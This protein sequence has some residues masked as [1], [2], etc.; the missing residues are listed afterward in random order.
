MEA[1]YAESNADFVRK[2]EIAPKEA[3]ETEI[4]LG[5]LYNI[6]A[7][8]EFTFKSLR[9]KCGKIRRMLIASVTTVKSKSNGKKKFCSKPKSSIYC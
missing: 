6:G 2:L 7:I 5:V 4:W 1:K 3:N 9:N 8:D